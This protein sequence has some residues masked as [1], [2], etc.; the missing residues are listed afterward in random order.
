MY[1]L[2]KIIE[3]CLE[4][5]ILSVLK[6]M[7]EDISLCISRIL[8]IREYFSPKKL[9]TASLILGVYREQ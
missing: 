4:N 5:L 6:R 8:E 2:K 1:I 7:C 9:L 3:K